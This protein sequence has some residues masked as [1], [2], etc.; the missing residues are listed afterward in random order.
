MNEIDLV[1]IQYMYHYIQYRYNYYQP[2]ISFVYAQKKKPTY[3][4]PKSIK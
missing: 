2:S 1:P 4:Y 3:M